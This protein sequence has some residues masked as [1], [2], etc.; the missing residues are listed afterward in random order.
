MKK[1]LLLVPL[2]LWSCASPSS[3]QDSETAFEIQV[4]STL[5]YDQS[6]LRAGEWVVYFVKRQGENSQPYRWAAVAEEGSALWIEN[7]VPFGPRSMVVKSK[8]DRT[9]KLLEQWTGEP[10]GVPEQ[11]FPNP[12]KADAPPARRD[13]STAKADSKED[14]DTIVAGGKSY[15][16]TRVTT[17]LTYPDGRKSTMINWFSK[18]VPFAPSKALGGLVKRRIGLLTMELATS[19]TQGALP[20]LVIPRPQ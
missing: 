1:I 10:G 4:A 3:E 9:G 6:L 16:C 14:P 7:K 19:D 8:I 13:P 17:A 18:E 5:S 20:E 15:G 2:A 11:T 12:Q